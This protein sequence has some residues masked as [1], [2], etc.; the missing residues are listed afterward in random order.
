M[1]PLL[2][3]VHQLQRKVRKRIANGRQVAG[4][5]P[6]VQLV[7]LCPYPREAAR[8]RSACVHYVVVHDGQRFHGCVWA[9]GY[10]P[11]M[12]RA[13]RG[14]APP[15]STPS[16]ILITVGAEEL[17]QSA[18]TVTLW[19]SVVSL[20]ATSLGILAS[21]L[22]RPGENSWLPNELK[23]CSVWKRGASTAS[24][25]DMPNSMMFRSTCSNA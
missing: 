25:G 12:N 18:A 7:P 17:L 15:S 22:S 2:G 11:K 23:K 8:V 24:C 10:R 13:R 1:I 16:E 14:S 19:P 4:E 6:R 21:R 20:S 5:Q 9:P 3:G